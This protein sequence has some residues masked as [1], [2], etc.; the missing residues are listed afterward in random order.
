MSKTHSDPNDECLDV[1]DAFLLAGELSTYYQDEER[2]M[3]NFDL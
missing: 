3:A 1:L 2:S